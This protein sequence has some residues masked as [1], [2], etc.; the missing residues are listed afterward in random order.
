MEDRY[1]IAEAGSEAGHRLGG[2]GDFGHEHDRAPTLSQ[3]V[4]QNLDV[5]QGLSRPRHT[6]QEKGLCWARVERGDQRSDGLLLAVGRGVSRVCTGGNVGKGIA[7]HLTVLHEGQSLLFQPADHAATEAGLAREV[8]Q[9]HRASGPGECL[10]GVRLSPCTAHQ[11]VQLLDIVDPPRDAHD[12]LRLHWRGTWRERLDAHHSG[13][14]EVAQLRPDGAHPQAPLERPD[15]L[16]RSG[17]ERFDQARLPRQQLASW[18]IVECD[19]VTGGVTEHR[20]KHRL[21]RDP[22]RRD[23]VV[24][25]PAS[26]AHL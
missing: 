1:L 6:V 14:S 25:H 21:E 11:H 9:L 19:H 5:D 20:R 10:V 26:Q 15:R 17:V 8:R 24:G 16:P 22:Q 12:P 13:G 23:I 7:V 4:V 3:H 18:P 2:Q